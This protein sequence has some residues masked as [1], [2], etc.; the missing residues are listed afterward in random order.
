MYQF[1]IYIRVDGYIT[2]HCSMDACYMKEQT[3]VCGVTSLLS[4]SFQRGHLCDCLLSCIWTGI[5]PSPSVSC[6]SFFLV[7]FLAVSVCLVTHC[8]S[9]FCRCL[10]RGALRSN[11]LNSGHR[12][13]IIY[14]CW[15][16]ES[17]FSSSPPPSAAS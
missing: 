16:K 2:V 5:C 13:S 11:P 4:V 15:S 10:E 8:I 17:R 1:I 12:K 7:C 9:G 3:K 14:E 6:I